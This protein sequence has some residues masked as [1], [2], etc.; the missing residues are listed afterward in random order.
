MARI[1]WSATVVAVTLLG[2]S[3]ALAQEDVV[4]DGE[5]PGVVYKK[6]TTYDF[7]DDVVEGSEVPVGSVAADQRIVFSCVVQYVHFRL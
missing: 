7:E 5:N 2:A 4:T 3:A 1:L 6:E